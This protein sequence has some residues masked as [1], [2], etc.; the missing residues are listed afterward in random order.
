MVK[1]IKVTEE[2]IQIAIEQGYIPCKSVHSHCGCLAYSFEKFLLV[3]KKVWAF[4]IPIHVI[5]IL[6]FKRKELRNKPREIILKT[7]FR[8]LKSL[9]FMSS[10]IGIIYLTLCT[11]VTLRKKFDGFNMALATFNMSWS[12][13]LEAESRRDEI[14]LYILPRFLESFWNFLKHRKIMKP[15]AGGENLLFGLATGLMAYYYHKEGKAMKGAY[16]QIF[17]KFWGIN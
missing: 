16:R 7:L 9:L 3:L 17:K 15:I 5:P 14:C 10:C 6:L 11:T 2:L 1:P 13:L 12:V 4:Y 8:Y